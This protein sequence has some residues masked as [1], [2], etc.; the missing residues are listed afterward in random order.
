M[1]LTQKDRGPLVSYYPSSEA[2]CP[3]IVQLDVYTR[4]RARA[5]LYIPKFCPLVHNMNIYFKTV[6]IHIYTFFIGSGKN[7]P[8]FLQRIQV[9]LT[10]FGLKM[11]WC[12]TPSILLIGMGHGFSPTGLVSN[13]QLYYQ[14]SLKGLG[15]A[16]CVTSLSL[17]LLIS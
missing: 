10:Q 11:Q 17:C 5:F 12:V 16:G 14:M 15:R 1:G 7:L 6:Y 2:I 3:R 9:I 4:K 8:P 13:S